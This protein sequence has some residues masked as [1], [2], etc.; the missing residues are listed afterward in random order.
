MLDPFLGT[1][2]PR[3]VLLAMA[4]AACVSSGLVVKS[5]TSL[6]SAKSAING[7]SVTV[8]APR[9]APVAVRSLV[10]RASKGEE[11]ETFS[12]RAA[13]ALVAGV[14]A[15]GAKVGSANAAYGESG[16]HWNWFLGLGCSLILAHAVAAM[17][18]IAAS[19]LLILLYV[20]FCP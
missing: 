4:C 13:L 6:A 19:G 12:R 5:S 2:N 15:A 17:L 20:G 3:L 7:A 11:G 1:A 14:L 8:A 16:K 10:V 18:T 9:V